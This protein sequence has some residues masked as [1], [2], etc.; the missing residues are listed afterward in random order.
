M[1]PESLMLY[2]LIILYILDSVE[3]PL[4]NNQITSF[5]LEKEYT[6]YLNIQEAIG[7]LL[8]DEYLEAESERLKQFYQ[9]TESGRE[10]LSLFR[11]SIFPG[12][13]SE[14]DAYLKEHQYQLREEVT[15]RSNFYRAKGGDYVVHLRILERKSAI[16]DL[17]IP[18]LTQVEANQLCKNWEEKNAELY[19]Y[20]L[21]NL[22]EEE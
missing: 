13:R 21:S 6:N 7:E 15:V 17:K 9:I 20:I 10:A 11:S 22:L 14:I 3:F 19:A 18:V 4:T 8:E 2:K 1:R 12:I 5:I 16:I